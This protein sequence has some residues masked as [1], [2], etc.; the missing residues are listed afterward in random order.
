MGGYDSI[1]VGAGVMGASAAYHLARAGRR[2]V[3]LEQYGLGHRRGSSHGHSRIIRCAYDHPLYVRLAAHAHRLWEALAR[4]AGEPLVFPS[5]GLDLGRRDHP[6]LQRI[7]DSLEAEGVGYEELD[8]RALEVRFRQFRPGPDWEAVYQPDTGVIPADR[9]LEVLLAGARARGAEVRD[10]TPVVGIEVRAAS[11]AVETAAGRLSAGSLILT[12]GSWAAG[13]LRR[14]GLDLPLRPMRQQVH[15]FAPR[16]PDD[17]RPGRFPA[18]IAWGDPPELA[19]T[20]YGLPILGL[21]GIKVGEHR[22]GPWIEDPDQP[23]AVDPRQTDKV[24]GFV[25]RLLPAAAGEPFYSETCRYTMTPDEHFLIDRHPEHGHVLVA[26]GFSGHGF[27]FGPLV[28]QAL[29]RMSQ[30]LPVEHDLG[31]FRMERLLRRE[32]AGGS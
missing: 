8:R 9:A 31:L 3:L 19:P 21:E 7:R 2:V 20:Y 23:D 30:G 27:K 4:E 24:A 16:E 18:F 25:E 32:P 1:I 6:V 11:V 14:L 13:L 17:Y 5:G 10:G 29:A 28:G 26:G 12:A 22:G 15:F